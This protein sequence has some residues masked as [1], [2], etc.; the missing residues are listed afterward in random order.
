MDTKPTIKNF[1]I[2]ILPAILAVFVIFFLI[3]PQIKEN[4]EKNNQVGVT[5]FEEC[6]AAGNPVMESYP[7][8]C[9]H[10]GQTFTEDIEQIVGGDKD[11]HG[12]I[13][14]AGYSWCEPKNECLRVWEEPC[15]ESLGQE[16]QYLLADKYSKPVDQVNVTVTKQTDTHAAGS[17]LFGDGGPGEGGMFL[18]AKI[19]ELWQVVFDGNGSVDCDKMREEYNFPDEILKPNF[20]D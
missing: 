2:V 14:S 15:Y 18:A 4:R 11:E 13:G 8:Q 9:R 10:S 20:C 7:R 17:V 19:D 16:I 5:N 3:M 6:V 1:L 12:C